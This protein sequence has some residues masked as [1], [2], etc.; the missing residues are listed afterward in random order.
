MCVSLAKHSL[1]FKTERNSDFVNS[2]SLESG[3]CPEG[4]VSELSMLW[5]CGEESSLV[6]VLLLSY[7]CRFCI[8][9]RAEVVVAKIVHIE[10]D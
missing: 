1:P 8:S 2:K 6:G 4:L 10:A 9:A 7:G 3:Y 5:S